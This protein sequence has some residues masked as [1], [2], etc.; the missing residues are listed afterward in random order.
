M[1]PKT[2]SKK[3]PAE[4]IDAATAKIPE[5]TPR[6]ENKK[7]DAKES[8]KKVNTR[9]KEQITRYKHT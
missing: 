6:R 9:T 3:T 2:T 8:A 7:K 4:N 1:D 5:V